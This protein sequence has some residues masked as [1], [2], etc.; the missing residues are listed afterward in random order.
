MADR[1]KLRMLEGFYALRM[2]SDSQ[3]EH[4]IRLA[5][6][7]LSILEE[8]N[9]P[10]YSLGKKGNYDFLHRGITMCCANPQNGIL[11][12]GI[13]PGYNRKFPNGGYYTFE[14]TMLNEE[15]HKSSYWRNKKKQIVG[16]DPFLLQR[17]AYLDLFPYSESSQKK[18]R[19][20]LEEI[21]TSIDNIQVKTLEV[22]L[23]EIEEHLRPKLI[24]A[25][26]KETAYYWGIDKKSTWLGY[27]LEPVA[28]LPSCLEGKSIILY[29]ITGTRFQ[30]EKKDR[31]G[32]DKFSGKSNILGAYFIS[33]AL[34]DDRHVSKYPQKILSPEIVKSLFEWIDRS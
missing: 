20:E 2:K 14:E 1:E 32:Q 3:K 15:Q 6:K 4:D 22:T 31:I 16:D 25:A 30:M 13:N 26:N 29:R 19:Q 9:S 10:E 24:I 8:V 18:F 7:Y 11:I 33:Y 23:E 28:S 5:N 12:T 27:Q 34:Y 21:G 17:T